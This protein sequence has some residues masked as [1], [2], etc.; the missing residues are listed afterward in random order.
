MRGLEE[1]RV[2]T[3]VLDKDEVLSEDGRLAG[4]EELVEGVQ[5]YDEEAEVNQ[6]PSLSS[7]NTARPP[8]SL[9]RIV[10]A[11]FFTPKGPPKTHSN[12]ASKSTSLALSRGTPRMPSSPRPDSL[13]GTQR[14]DPVVFPRDLP[15]ISSRE[16]R[17]SSLGQGPVDR[18]EVH[19]GGVESV[20][21]GLGLDSL[22]TRRQHRIHISHEII[23]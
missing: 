3:E 17:D 15:S 22:Y 2:V 12:E 13:P 18:Q 16:D 14:F 20:E 21:F 1:T 7:L 5:G 19:R 6:V 10:L 8:T 11:V 4:F 9:E 23:G